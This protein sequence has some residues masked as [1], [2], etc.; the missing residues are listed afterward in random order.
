MSFFNP[1]MRTDRLSNA[2]RPWTSV[3]SM[4][5]SYPAP[6]PPVGVRPIDQ[7]QIDACLNCP[8][9]TCN[10]KGNICRKYRA[11]FIARAEGREP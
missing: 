7:A 2:V 5:A 10:G 1:Q 9:P 3:D 4:S 8:Y 11:H 6:S